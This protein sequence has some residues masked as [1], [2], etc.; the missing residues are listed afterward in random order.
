MIWPRTPGSRVGRAGELDH[1]PKYRRRQ[2]WDG[3]NSLAPPLDHSKDRR[4]AAGDNAA[5]AQTNSDTV[6]TNE[7][8]EIACLPRYRDQAECE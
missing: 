5:P 4:V 6:V 2:I 1:R 3:N 7:P 8:R